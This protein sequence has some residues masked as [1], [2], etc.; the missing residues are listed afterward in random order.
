MLRWMIRSLQVFRIGAA[1]G[2]ARTIAALLS[3]IVILLGF[4]AAPSYSQVSV[5]TQNNDNGR[6]AVYSNETALTPALLTASPTTFQKLF[7]ITVDN[8]V[9]GQALILGGVTAPGEPTNILLAFTS[10]NGSSSGPSSLWAFNADTG[11]KLWQLSFGTISPNNTPTPVI[12]PTMGTN[13]AIYVLTLSS[14]GT[15]LHAID[16]ILGTELTGSPITVSASVSGTSF[17]S[18]QQNDRAA[19]LLVNGVVYPS[20]SHQYDTGTYH[21]WVIGYKYTAGSGFTQTGV[22]CDTP[23]G[24]QGGIWQGGDGLIADSSGDVYA[25]SGNGSFS[26][27]TGGSNYGMSVVRLVPPGLSVADWFAPSDESSLSDNDE[28]LNGGGMVLIPGTTDIFLGPS[29]FGSFFLVNTTNLGHFQVSGPVQRFN[30]F[31]AAVARSPIAWNSGSAIYAYVW[32]SSSSIEQF[33][34]DTST[35]EFSPAGVYKASSFTAGGSLAISSAPDGSNPILWAAGGSELHAMNPNDVSQADYWNSNMHSGDSLG[36]TG[37]YQFPVIANGKV[38]VPTGSSTIVVYGLTTPPPPPP[39]PP[40]SLTATAVSSSGINLSWTASTT[41]G[42]TYSVFRSTT[43]GFTASSSNQIAS[44]LST[45]SYS[46]INLV[47]NTT[48]YYLTEAI[49]SG[50]ASSASNQASATTQ[51]CSTCTVTYA[52]TG[53]TI[54]ASSGQSES[55][56]ADANCIG[57]ECVFYDSTATGNYISFD[58][59]IPVAQTYDIQVSYK[60]I[61]TRGIMQMAIASSVGGTYTNVGSTV[62]QY[63]AAAGYPTTDL[64]NFT[65]SSAGTWVFRFTVTGK[66]GASSSYTLSFNQLTLTPVSS[67]P[68]NPPSSLTATAASSSEINLSWMASTTSGVTY[69]VFRSTTSGFTAS[70]GNQIASGVTD[71]EYSDT[72]LAASTAYY[73]LVEA[74]DSGGVSTP[75]NQAS[76]TTQGSSGTPVTYAFTSLSIAASSGQSES[77][78]SDANCDGGE[79]VF[80]DSTAAGN[81]ISFDVDVPT[82]GTYDIQVSYK[83]INTRGIMQMAVASSVGGTYTNVGPTVDQYS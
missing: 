15:K 10:S 49:L 5:L 43:S 60:T 45:T 25:A 57:G 17:D 82:S 16:P 1:L 42:V 78:F 72:G 36:S 48:Y 27:N 67:S 18:S 6:D 31:N 46:D 23:S 69:S 75:S 61:N 44:G 8:N 21:G 30:G 13:G 26:A 51:S 80:Y 11:A 55:E 2:S 29:K 40:T 39:N 76:A 38:Y 7:T 20:F 64:G 47:Q 22:F 52:F 81:Y 35:A 74:V 9:H 28:D 68:P 65:F 37:E 83:T 4:L 3:T 66:D 19:L 33:S 12:D 50:V 63:S 56:F 34:Y 79:C 58:V 53:L 62:D 41:S 59:P 54:A 32:P 70:S 73:Y 77:E 71:T 24:N 14:S